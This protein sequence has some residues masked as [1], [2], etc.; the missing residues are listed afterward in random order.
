[1]LGAANRVVGGNNE[2]NR[3]VIGR[4]VLLDD[5]SV[6]LNSNVGDDDVAARNVEFGCK[7]I[8][9]TDILEGKMRR[10]HHYQQYA[11]VIAFSWSSRQAGIATTVTSPGFDPSLTTSRAVFTF[12]PTK[13]PPIART[14]SASRSSV[15]SCGMFAPCGTPSE[16]GGSTVRPQKKGARFTRLH[17]DL[18]LRMDGNSASASLVSV[19]WIT[20]I[21]SNGSTGH[22]PCH[23]PRSTVRKILP[24]W[25][26]FWPL[27]V[28]V[29]DKMLLERL[30]DGEDR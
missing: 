30:V 4:T 19:L 7:A 27:P 20:G 3:D 16:T 29:V 24:R 25:G 18:S 13:E 26:L 17:D 11:D 10:Y 6:P 1:M 15:S 8:R 2:L 12:E 22:D 5:G 21:G 9:L 23:T 28:G 14:H